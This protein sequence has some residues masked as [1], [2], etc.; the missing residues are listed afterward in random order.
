LSK[1]RESHKIQKKVFDEISQTEIIKNKEQIQ[2]FSLAVSSTKE[3]KENLIS[4]RK[5]SSPKMKIINRISAITDEHSFLENSHS[6]K[7]KIDSVSPDLLEFKLESNIVS[8]NFSNSDDDQ[9]IIVQNPSLKNINHNTSITL[10]LDEYE[11]EAL[12][13]KSDF[14]CLYKEKMKIVNKFYVDKINE[15]T[16]DFLKLKNKMKNRKQTFIEDSM[17][18]K[19][20]NF[21]KSMIHKMKKEN[22]ERDELGFAVSWKRALSQLYNTASW[23]NSYLTINNIANQKIIKKMERVFKNSDMPSGKE[24]IE[25]ITKS[26][27]FSDKNEQV[28]KV[29]KNIKEFYSEELT[30]K[31]KHRAKKELEERMKGNRSKDIVTI[32]FYSGMI[33]SFLLSFFLLSQIPSKYH[34]LLIIIIRNCT[35]R[36]FY[37][38]LFPSFQLCV[39]NSFNSCW[40]GYKHYGF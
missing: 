40:I 30:D 28:I 26:F 12:Q 3:L 25:E 21:S 7:P 11:I 20:V 9:S 1:L 38:R 31:D 15:I 14:I 34:T 33:I 4:K 37:F 18:V 19:D 6:Q 16:N 23:L 27:N 32:A 2:R 39:Y 10:P 36:R 22:A 17:V 5:I 13:L 8:I 24:E 35:N 29:S